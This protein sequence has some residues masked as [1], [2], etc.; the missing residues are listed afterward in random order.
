MGAAGGSRGGS[1]PEL[2]LTDTAGSRP[3]DTQPIH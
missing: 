3:A 1:I 2:V